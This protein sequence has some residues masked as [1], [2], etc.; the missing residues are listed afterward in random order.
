MIKPLVLVVLDGWGLSPIEVGNPIMSTP[1]PNFDK[2]MSMF[3]NTSVKASGEEVGLSWGEVGNSEVGH[4]NLGTGRVIQ[5]DLPRINQS[6]T[7]GDFFNNESL[8]G[9]FKYVR[10]NNSSL[11]II[12]LFSAG[13]VHSHLNH[14][15]ALLDFAV[16]EKYSKVYIHLISDGRDTPEKTI[17][18]DIPKLQEKIIST[19]I[20]VV[21]SLSGRFYAMD[22]DKRY[23]R[24]AKAFNVLT[25]AS[26]PKSPSVSEAI[27][28]SYKN[29][30][31]DEFIKP[32]QIGD[33]PKIR[34]HDGVI[35]FN[36]RSDRARQISDLIIDIPDIYFVSF[37]SYGH[38]STPR[39]KVAFFAD[40]VTNQL[41]MTLSKNSLPQLHIAETEKYPH[42]TYFF[43][44]GYE[45]PFPLEERILVPSPHVETYD[46]APEM[47][48][49]IV[50]DEFNNYFIQ[51]K[52]VFTV[53]NFAN[54]DMVG[55]TGDIE[56][57][58]KAVATV[59]HS[60]GQLAKTVLNN[61][62][63]LIV[64][65]DHGNAEQM[66]NPQTGEVDKEHTTNPVPLILA[67][68]ERKF[69]NLK[70]VTKETKQALASG[71]P[72]GVL[73]DITATILQ[74]LSLEASPEIV[75]QSLLDVI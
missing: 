67:F 42:V 5:Q 72:T 52:P 21:A 14:L 20:G 56:A 73:T 3:L 7:K 59:D 27:S 37:T 22:R 32:I 26:S 63:N 18:K 33:S 13:G 1:T 19:G 35:F 41:A 38:E 6:I 2:L 57:T 25:N 9:V 31:T 60:L 53:L 45:S 65:A 58:K 50:V 64:T 4:L 39:I 12:G 51:K 23:E 48:A 74:S 70:I 69:K 11:H 36:F 40:K 66:I 47:S 44:G 17:L 15:F 8:K 29:N 34:S 61:S 46:I 10:E 28:A 75:G 49:N 62:G 16:Q 24:T 54:T 30:I 55:H 68:P 71:V 43:N